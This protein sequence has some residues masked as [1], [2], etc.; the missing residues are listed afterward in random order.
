L[1]ESIKRFVVWYKYFLRYFDRD[2]LEKAREV[3]KA[4]HFFNYAHKR[5][6]KNRKKKA[7]RFLLKNWGRKVGF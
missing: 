2:R 1:L 3:K 6:D 7:V 4:S 5:E